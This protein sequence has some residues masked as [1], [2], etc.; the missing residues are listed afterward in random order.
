MFWELLQQ[1]QINNATRDAL[2]AN[3]RAREAGHTSKALEERVERLTLVC[4]AMWE[5]LNSHT[6][7]TED[8]LLDQMSEVDL[9][10][11]Q[12]DGVYRSIV[13][14][15]KCQR[16]VSGRQPNCLYCGAVLPDRKAFDHVG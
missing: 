15:A 4:R 10:D 14:C 7:L 6:G 11:G 8:Q 3:F 13:H 9:S 2:D 5:L 12:L 1:Q 16:R